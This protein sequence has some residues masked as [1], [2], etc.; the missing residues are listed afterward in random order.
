MKHCSAY[1]LADVPTREQYGKQDVEDEVMSCQYVSLISCHED[2]PR[3]EHNASKPL[4]HTHD[5]LRKAWQLS[6]RHVMC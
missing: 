1:V 2:G 6:M 4:M 5:E 3:R